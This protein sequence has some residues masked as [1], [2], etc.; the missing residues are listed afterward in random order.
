MLKMIEGFP[1]FNPEPL[2]NLSQIKRFPFQGFRNLF[3]QSLHLLVPN[4][5]FFPFA[6]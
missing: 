4:T 2:R 6:L 3:P 1:L 5:I